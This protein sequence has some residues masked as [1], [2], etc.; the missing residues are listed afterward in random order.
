M[1]VL[2]QIYLLRHGIAESH[3]TSGADSDRELTA[4]GRQKVREVMK[5]A[6][7]AGVRPSLILTSPYRRALG[8]A[9]IAAEVLDYRGELARSNALTPEQRPEGV[10]EEIRTLRGETSVML[11][12]HEPLF[13]SLSAF[14]LG[15]PELDVDFKKGALLALEIG[16]FGTRPHGVLKWLLT[17]KLVS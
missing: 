9:Q 13:S 12:G 4:E 5:A 3:S 11:V 7:K 1:M 17:A 2:M 10:W 15:V 16:G 6:A 14:L 8:T